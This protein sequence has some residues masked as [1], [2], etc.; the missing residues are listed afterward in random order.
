MLRL[1]CASLLLSCCAALKIHNATGDDDVCKCLSFHHVYANGLA[2]CGDGGESGEVPG[3]YCTLEGDRPITYFPMQNHSR[4]LRYNTEAQDRS[5]WCYVSTQ[6]ADRN[7]GKFVNSNVSVKTCGE[8]DPKLGDLPASELFKLWP[9]EPQLATFFSYQYN[10]TT[11]TEEGSL[12]GAPFCTYEDVQVVLGE[13]A[14][15]HIKCQNGEEWQVHGM[16]A[17]CLNGCQVESGRIA[18]CVGWGCR[19]DNEIGYDGGCGGE[20]T[21]RPRIED[22]M[23]G[24]NGVPEIGLIHEQ[25]DSN[26]APLLD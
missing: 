1:A 24:P 18:G 6:C 19:P 3:S 10:L 20:P 26:A 8:D 16:V 25:D 15:P 17:K 14:F 7:G 11:P 21:C 13:E 4:C 23:Y 2:S 22:W 12:T 5:T 9:W